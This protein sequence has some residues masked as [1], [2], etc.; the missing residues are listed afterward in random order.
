MHSSYE[1]AGAR[2]TEYL[3]RAAECFYVCRFL[4]EEDG[5]SLL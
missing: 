1:T 3:I 2:N 4:R 5:I